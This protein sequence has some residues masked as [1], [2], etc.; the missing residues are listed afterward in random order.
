MKKFK[1]LLV[2]IT[3]MIMSCKKENNKHCWRFDSTYTA[4]FFPAVPSDFWIQNFQNGGVYA[5]SHGTKCDLNFE[6][7]EQIRIKMWVSCKTYVWKDDTTRTDCI[8]QITKT[9]LD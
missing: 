4:T 1:L 9:M 2:I 7:A 5:H 8:Q 6:E 3:M